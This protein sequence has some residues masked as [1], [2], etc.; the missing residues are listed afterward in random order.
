MTAKCILHS[1]QLEWRGFCVAKNS[2]LV[3]LG[4]T[5]RN[6][7]D[8]H[9]VWLMLGAH[10]ERKKHY[11]QVVKTGTFRIYCACFSFLVEM[12]SW[13]TITSKTPRFVAGSAEIPRE[14]TAVAMQ[15]NGNS[16]WFP[17]YLG[18]SVQKNAGRAFHLTVCNI[19]WHLRCT[20]FS[21]FYL[22]NITI[23]F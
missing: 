21:I 2:G 5:V 10:H 15:S 4:I 19:S 6:V 3:D 14:P 11:V 1:L 12:T 8:E 20:R 7:R 22:F 13:P 23:L 18:R 16:W 9:R 17:R